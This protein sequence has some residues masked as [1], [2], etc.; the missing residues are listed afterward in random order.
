MN[1]YYKIRIAFLYAKKRFYRLFLVKEDYLLMEFIEKFLYGLGGSSEH[2][3]ELRTIEPMDIDYEDAL[4][5]DLP[6]KSLLVYDFGDNWLFEITK[7][8]ATKELGDN[9]CTILI[10]GKGRSIW[11]D[12][13]NYFYAFLAGEITD[14]NF[15]EYDIDFLPYDHEKPSDFDL[16]IEVEK[17]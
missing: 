4:V 7:Y 12:F 5:K 11:D 3:H 1:R 6:F 9:R 13:I 10:E 2:L 14:D 15:T 8:K 16:P 17:L